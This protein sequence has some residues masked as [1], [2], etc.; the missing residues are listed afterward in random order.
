MNVLI[1]GDVI[2]GHNGTFKIVSNIAHG[3]KKDHKVR[4]VFYGKTKDNNNVIDLIDD[5]D[6]DI[7]L[8]NKFLLFIERKIKSILTRKHSNFNNEDIPSYFAQLSLYKFLKNINFSPDVIIF[9]NIFCSFSLLRKSRFEKNIVLFHEAPIFDDFNFL[10]RKLL[11]IY[12]NIL[13]KKSVFISISELTTLKTQNFFNFNIVTKPPIGFLDK[14]GHFQ[15]E[16]YI[17]LDTRWSKNRDPLFI[18]KIAPLVKNIKIIMHGIILDKSLEGELIDRIR[19][20]GYNIS[21]VHNDD[22]NSLISL[23]ERALIVLRWNGLNETGNS[24]AFLDAISYDCIPIVDRAMGSSRF[25]AENISPDLVVKKD[26]YI[27]AHVIN[28]VIDD[29]DYRKALVSK[30][31]ECKKRFTWEQ[32][33]ES[34]IACLENPK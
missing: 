31:K 16:M 5:I 14:S 15:K 23:Y 12:L 7:L 34:L 29:Q 27:I 32:Y 20:D 26:E 8:P 21:I 25:V 1:V 9:T 33:S 11:Y 10:F 22:S 17:L 18:L 6:Y 2:N 19:K 30:V 13:Y 28:K 24:L 3:F 4:L